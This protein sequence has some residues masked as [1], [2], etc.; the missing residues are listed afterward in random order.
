MHKGKPIVHGALKEVKKA[1]GK[2][3]LVIHSD[4]DLDDL[5]Q[6][7][8]VIQ[9]KKTTEGVSLQIEKESI[10]SDILKNIVHKGF[11]SKFELEEPSLN[12]IFIEK[13][14]ASYEVTFGRSD[15]SYLYK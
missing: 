3:N 5:L 12:D 8:G 1:F 14:G 7:P 6:Y 2:K 4:F 9:E 15:I 10:A 13:V 11:I